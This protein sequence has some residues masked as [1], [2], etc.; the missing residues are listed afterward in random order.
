MTESHITLGGGCFWCLEAVFEHVQGVTAV[1]NGYCN[2]AVAAPT[3]EQVCTGQTGCAEVVRVN[4]G[5]NH[6]E[7]VADSHPDAVIAS[8]AD[9]TALLAQR[10]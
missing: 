6:G 3:Y 2:G 10:A 1:E 8:L 7:P 5:Y 4:Y 9:L